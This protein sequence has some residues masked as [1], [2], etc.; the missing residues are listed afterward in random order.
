MPRRWHWPAFAFV[1]VILAVGAASLGVI[2]PRTRAA[3]NPTNVGVDDTAMQAAVNAAGWPQQ[4]NIWCGVATITAIARYRGYGATQ[5]GVAAFLNSSAAVSQWGTPP[6][7]GPG[8]G[9]QANISRDTGS[10][11]RAL[12]EGVSAEAG[13]TYTQMVDYWG[14]WNATAHLAADIEYSHQPISVIVASGQHSVVVSKIFA[15]GD[16]A[17]NPGSIY[18]LEVWDPG[19][20]AN[21]QIQG[22]QKEIVSLSTWLYDNGYWGAPYDDLLDPDPAVGPYAGMH[23][24]TGHYVYIRPGGI[25]VSV[26]WALNQNWIV[27]P[28]AHGELPPGYSLPTPTPTPTPTPAPTRAARPAPTSVA[29]AA[30]T[31]TGLSVA[32]SAPGP[33][34]VPTDTPAPAFILTPQ[35]MCVGITCVET[36]FSTWWILAIAAG[37]LATGVLLVVV[38]NMMRRSARRPLR[39]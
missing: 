12:A 7:A 9:F 21:A 25:G 11:P 15:N 2:P 28:G 20:G 30:P 13:G 26:D 14:A 38:T 5:A 18:A 31:A 10:D 37:L 1:A 27:I 23:L 8:L 3:P 29:Y 4:T 19:Y 24:W 39:D 36:D 22:A 35:S 34:D 6:P 32:V 16:P 33:P 17:S